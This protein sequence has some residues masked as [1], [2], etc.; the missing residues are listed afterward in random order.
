[1]I[2]TY[3]KEKKTNNLNRHQKNLQKQKPIFR[4]TEFYYIIIVESFSFYNPL[5]LYILY[6]YKIKIDSIFSIR[7]IV[8]SGPQ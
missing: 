8:I 7:N 2:D 3:Q 5:Q 1:M 4:C 6:M